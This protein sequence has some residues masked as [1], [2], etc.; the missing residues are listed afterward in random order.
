LGQRFP[1]FD[2]ELLEHFAERSADLGDDPVQP[3]LVIVSEQ[4]HRVD[5]ALV[6]GFHRV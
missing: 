3:V 4:D 1:A 5:G 6:G 2:R